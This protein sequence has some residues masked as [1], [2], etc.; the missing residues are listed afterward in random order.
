MRISFSQE[1]NICQIRLDF[2]MFESDRADAD[3][4]CLT[5]R[6]RITNTITVDST[7]ST[8]GVLNDQHSKTLDSSCIPRNS[9][10]LRVLI[11]FVSVPNI[12]ESGFNR[13]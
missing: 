3:G 12:W 8:C 1:P 7:F 6:L 10:L 9:K 13:S 4:N 11:V 5:D 2:E